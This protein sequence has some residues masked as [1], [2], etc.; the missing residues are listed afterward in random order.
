MLVFILY[1]RCLAECLIFR[2]ALSALQWH[3]CSAV[4]CFWEVPLCNSCICD[5]ITDYLFTAQL[6]SCWSGY[7]AVWLLHSH[8][9]LL[10]SQHMLCVHPITSAVWLLHSHMK[11]LL[12]Q[13]MLCVHPITSAV[14]LLHCWCHIKLLPSQHMLGVHPIT[15]A[16]WL[17]H[18]WC[19]MKLLLSQHMFCVHPTA[20]HQFTVSLYFKPHM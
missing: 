18:S 1:E 12:S 17:L 5:W 8:M 7:S 19:H 16:V 9:K 6:D 10:P 2:W 20:K 3:L 13:H 4:L 15:S 11:L 14:W